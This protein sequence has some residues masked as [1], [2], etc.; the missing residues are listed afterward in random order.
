MADGGCDGGGGLLH[1]EQLSP[2]IKKYLKLKII[3]IIL[4]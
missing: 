4:S 1:R 2:G 3:L